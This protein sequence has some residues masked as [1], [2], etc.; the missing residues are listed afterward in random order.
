MGAWIFCSSTT[1][2]TFSSKEREASAFL[3][4]SFRRSALSIACFIDSMLPISLSIHNAPEW[5]QAVFYPKAPVSAT[6]L[7]IYSLEKQGCA[8]RMTMRIIAKPDRL[9]GGSP[10]S[11]VPKLKRLLGVIAGF[12]PFIPTIPASIHKRLEQGFLQGFPGEDRD[13]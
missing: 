4:A 10:V 6:S 7:A 11:Y 5:H 1:I 12:A 3:L 9:S 2:R 8:S 13:D